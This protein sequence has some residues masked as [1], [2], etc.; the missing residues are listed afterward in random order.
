MYVPDRRERGYQAGVREY[1]LPAKLP[2]HKEYK[3]HELENP[4]PG[5][6]T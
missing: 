5:H 4:G 2:V 6:Q 1:S 3:N